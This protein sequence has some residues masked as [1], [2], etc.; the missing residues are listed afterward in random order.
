M[1][2]LLTPWVLLVSM[3]RRLDRRLLSYT[4]NNQPTLLFALF[5]G[6]TTFIGTMCLYPACIPVSRTNL[7]HFKQEGFI[8]VL[9]F[10]VQQFCLILINLSFWPFLFRG[11]DPEPIFSRMSDPDSDETHP[12]PQPCFCIRFAWCKSI[13]FLAHPVYQGN[14]AKKNDKFVL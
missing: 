11:S 3:R 8:S 5:S 4:S 7:C 14:I 2:L 13:Y 1:R 9:T 10:H 6:D 12:D